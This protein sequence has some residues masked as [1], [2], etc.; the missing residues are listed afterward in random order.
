M[1]KDFKVSKKETKLSQNVLIKKYS[2][3]DRYKSTLLNVSKNTEP[4]ERSNN[5]EE[6]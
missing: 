6:F 1:A 4:E 2:V 5:I 3:S